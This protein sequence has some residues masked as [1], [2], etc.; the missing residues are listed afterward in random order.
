[1][2]GRPTI[3]DVAERAGV[4]IATVSRVLNDSG[5]VSAP[6][7]QRVRAAASELGY[8]ADPAARALVSGQT[9]LGGVVGRD[10]PG[11]RDLALIFFGKGLAAV[12]PRLSQARDEPL[13][14]Q[15]L[16]PP[17]AGFRHPL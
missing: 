16:S 15:E 1:M 4:S 9:R 8:A 13:L 12:S 14:L 2:S 6:T 5:D 10:Q 7:R 17:S 11:H 3:H